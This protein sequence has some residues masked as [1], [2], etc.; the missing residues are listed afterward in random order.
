M[1][2]RLGLPLLAVLLVVLPRIAVYG[3][4]I[5]PEPAIVIGAGIL[6][7]LVTAVGTLRRAR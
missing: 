4:P 3:T 1:M 2:R 5:A 6:Y 7:A